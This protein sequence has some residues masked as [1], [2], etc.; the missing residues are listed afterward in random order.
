MP[1]AYQGGTAIGQVT[2]AAA[3]DTG[4]PKE[5][6]VVTGG[7]DH[8]CASFAVG[9]HK[10]GSLLDSTGTSESLILTTSQVLRSPEMS[11]QNF[12]QECHVVGKRYAV[13]AGFPVAGYAVEWL[14]RIM[15]HGDTMPDY[16]LTE[17]AEVPRGS[18]GLFFVPHLRGS[19]SPTFD[20]ACRGTL[21]GLKAAHGRG[22]L[23]RA[24]IEGVCYELRSNVLALEATVSQ[25]VDRI[26]AAG[27]VTASDLWLQLKAD[28]SGKTLTVPAV[29]ETAGL[30]AALLAGLGAGVY[31][32]PDEALDSLGASYAETRPRPDYAAFYQAQYDGFYSRIYPTLRDLYQAMS[33]R[34]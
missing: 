31:A 22:H 21:V 11:R 25:R 14:N 32:S 9:A 16:G 6:T 4:L 20:P 1:A 12:A 13:L 3:A 8:I 24:A 18:E 17:A 23:L 26:Y 34:R 19:G 27:K 28:I 15:E 5:T 2:Q 7:H 33:E 10:P 29:S 30:G